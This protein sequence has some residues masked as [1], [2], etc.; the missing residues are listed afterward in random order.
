MNDLK[1]S[2]IFV[3]VMNVWWYIT[4]W[5]VYA[6]CLFFDRFIQP[7]KVL[8]EQSDHLC[9]KLHRKQENPHTITKTTKY[10]LTYYCFKNVQRIHLAFMKED[11]WRDN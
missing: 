10:L 1:S 11:T 5:V 2:I 3:Y 4:E 8:N 9:T 6:V 7:V